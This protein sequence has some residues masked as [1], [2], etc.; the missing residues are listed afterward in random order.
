MDS[1]IIIG[2]DPAYLIIQL[3]SCFLQSNY[4]KSLHAEWRHT[5]ENGALPQT[6]VHFRMPGL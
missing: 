4:I 5:E 6:P 3:S 2:F 1:V